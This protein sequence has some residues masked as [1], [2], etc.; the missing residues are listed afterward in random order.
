MRA[1]P[2]GGDAG[3]GGAV[4]GESPP[5]GESMAR[6][7]DLKQ[8]L[9]HVIAVRVAHHK[10]EMIGNLSHHHIHQG[11]HVKGRRQTQQTLQRPTPL[12]VQRHLN[13]PIAQRQSRCECISHGEARLWRIA[14]W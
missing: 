3:K 8:L 5:E 7:R 12:L 14:H 6:V 11:R 4:G 10:P 13:H 9:T 1:A 2:V